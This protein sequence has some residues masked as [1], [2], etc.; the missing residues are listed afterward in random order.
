MMILI[1]TKEDVENDLSIINEVAAAWWGQ[2]GYTIIQDSHGKCVVGKNAQTGEDNINAITRTWDLARPIIFTID[3]TGEVI[4]EQET[5]W[6]IIDPASDP[7]FV[8][9]RNYLP[10]GTDIKCRQENVEDNI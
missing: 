4:P 1:G 2:Q 3:D 10:D 6:F 7:R 9:W 8:D 5:E